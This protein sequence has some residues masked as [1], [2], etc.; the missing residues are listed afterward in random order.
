MKS[1]NLN[2]M[3]HSGPHWACYGTALPLSLLRVG[4]SLGTVSLS[5]Q[6]S[7]PEGSVSYIGWSQKRHGSVLQLCECRHNK[8]PA[9]AD[10]CV[11]SDV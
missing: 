5:V 10:V 6:L 4:S 2:L 8:R 9:G 3:E 1:G 11:E 7:A